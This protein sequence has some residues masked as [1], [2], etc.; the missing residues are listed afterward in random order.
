MNKRTKIFII[1]SVIVLAVNILARCIVDCTS[2]KVSIILDS[3]YL[4]VKHNFPDDKYTVVWETDAGSLYSAEEKTDYTA[5]TK[6]SYYL[7]TGVNDRVCWNPQDEDGFAYCTATIKITIFRYTHTIYTQID[8]EIYTAFLTISGADG[9]ISKVAERQFGNPV[10]KNADDDW[11][12]ILVLNHLRGFVVLRYRSG[13]EI[14]KSETLVWKSNT[15]GLYNTCFNSDTIYQPCKAGEHLY[16]LSGTTTACFSLWNFDPIYYDGTD[17][18]LYPARIRVFAAVIP[19][20]DRHQY[21]SPFY[22]P[23]NHEE[24]NRAEICIQYSYEIEDDFYY[25]IENLE[26][27]KSE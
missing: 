15:D 23:G 20:K 14:A 10:R 16:M 18:R 7:Y 5:P 24:R 26:P 25:T 4:M 6:N 11:Q 8:T 27:G 1:M 21:K 17:D 3:N 12:Q 9:K 2:P 13:K 19:E 22:K